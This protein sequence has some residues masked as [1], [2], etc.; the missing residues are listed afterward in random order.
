MGT[1]YYVRWNPTPGGHG[2]AQLVYEPRAYIEL[3]IC[4]SLTMFQGAVFNSWNAWRHFLE[5]NDWTVEVRDEYGV[6]Y[7]TKEFIS[8]VDGTERAQRR[9][10]YDAVVSNGRT[11]DRDWLDADFFSFYSGEFS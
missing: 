3:H 6:E 10:Q 4:K 1:N 7:T 8:M 5:S 2:P 9:R 11:S